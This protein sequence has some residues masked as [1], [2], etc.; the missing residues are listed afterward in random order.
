[1]LP[2]PACLLACWPTWHW[3]QQYRSMAD[4]IQ[5]VIQRDKALSRM[6]NGSRVGPLVLH[7]IIQMDPL[8]LQMLQRASLHLNVEKVF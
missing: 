8:L 5:N 1:V 6:Q 3:P 2:V 7:C 4:M